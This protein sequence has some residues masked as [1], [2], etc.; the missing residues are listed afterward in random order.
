[1]IYKSDMYSKIYNFY[2][3]MKAYEQYEIYEWS[4][5]LLL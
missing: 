2:E 3:K 1:M 4:L 5:T